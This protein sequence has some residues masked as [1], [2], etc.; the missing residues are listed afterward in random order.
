[1]NI[2][3]L[4]PGER[5]TLARQRYQRNFLMV[6]ALLGAVI[7]GIL[8]GASPGAG[9]AFAALAKGQLTLSPL[10]A[11]LLALALVAGLVVLPIYGFRTIDEVK[12]RRSLWSMAAAWFVVIAGYPVWAVLAAGGLLPQPSAVALFIAAYGATMIAFVVLRLR[13]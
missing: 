13:G 4:G 6:G 3:K 7:G 2:D 11:I 8:G 10:T 9:S 5:A 1:M 12:V